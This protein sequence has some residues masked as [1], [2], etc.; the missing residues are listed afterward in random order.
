[1]NKRQR[2][3]KLTGA[4]E[5]D[6]ATPEVAEEPTGGT[7]LEQVLADI[8]KTKGAAAVMPASQIPVANHIPTGSFL[9]DF[10]L[11][12]GI[13]EGYVSMF[14]GL[15]SSGKTTMIKKIVGE[16]QKKHPSKV[17]AWVDAEGMFD[18]DWA[19][20]LG[21]DVEKLL[22][23][24]PDTGQEAVDVMEAMMGAWEVG[25][26][27]L[28][29]IPACVPKKILENSAEDLT[30]SELARLM[31]IFC[32][33]VAMS[34]SAE[35]KRGHH[36]TVLLVNQFRAKIGVMFGDPRTLPGG[37]QIN[38]LPSTKV[39][40]RN[41]EELGKDRHDN[42]VV[43]YNGHTF[44]ITKSKHGSSI[45]NGEFRMVINPDNKEGLPQGTINDTDTLCAYAKKMGFI[46]GGGSSWVIAGVD[47]KFRKLDEI[48]AY[49]RG[50]EGAE[51]LLR[52]TVIAAQREAKGLPALPPDGYL[53]GGW[54][55]TE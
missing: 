28:D 34:F 16:F 50:T 7:E 24:R 53:S 14:Y 43:E 46:T 55:S 38:H 8:A 32:S 22:V 33:K 49:L 27:V 37:R 13:P 39:E 54:L 30:M 29:S 23:S 51:M 21:V 3:P 17:A 40:I 41:L 2:K 20:K 18:K 10:A 12:G 52:Q 35:R 45:K 15:E 36:V 6:E 19:T 44:K 31:G 26:I 5:F 11:L 25:L 48:R 1:M 42:E 47:Q 4:E 9:L